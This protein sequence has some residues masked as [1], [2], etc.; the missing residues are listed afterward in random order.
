MKKLC[1]LILCTALFLQILCACSQ[2]KEELVQPTDFYYCNS[3]IGYNSISA[4]IGSERREAVSFQNNI[5]T[6][7]S[8]YLKGP[9]S[10][11]LYSPV[12]ATASLI[13]SS[14]SDGEL[15]LEFNE[16]FSELSGVQLSICCSCILMTV[17]AFCGVETVHFSASDALLEDRSEI[18]LNI[19][20]VVLQDTV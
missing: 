15:Y 7:L 18:V 19:Q 20:D 6:M 1:I 16:A 17:Y 12:P 8:A 10:P 5:D 2:K 13:G 14:L 3:E 4:V 9:S 11:D